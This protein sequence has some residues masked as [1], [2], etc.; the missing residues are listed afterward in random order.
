MEIVE[1]YQLRIWNQKGYSIYKGLDNVKKI[2][3]VFNIVEIFQGLICDTGKIIFSSNMCDIE[4]LKQ[5]L[6]LIKQIK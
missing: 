2:D 1:I 5:N 3:D 4:E 6:K